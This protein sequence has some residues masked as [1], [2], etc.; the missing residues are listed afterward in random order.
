ML[1]K[2]NREPVARALVVLAVDSREAGVAGP[3]R[4]YR[5]SADGIVISWALAYQ[6]GWMDII[7]RTIPGTENCIP[8]ILV[9]VQRKTAQSRM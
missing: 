9:W 8:S 4:V 3:G 6:I 7:G 5:R 1:N 2:V